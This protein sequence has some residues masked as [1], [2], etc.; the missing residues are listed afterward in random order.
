[1]E[2]LEYIFDTLLEHWP[3]VCAI[4]M[5]Y[6]IGQLFKKAAP[7]ASEGKFWA[8]L[9]RILPLHPFLLGLIMGMIPGA[10][11]P[12]SAKFGPLSGMLYFAGAGVIACHIRDIVRT[13]AKYKYNVD[14]PP[15]IPP[16]AEGEVDIDVSNV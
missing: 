5:F 14:I 11:V 2:S 6:S 16:S 7:A 8:F 4:G 1:M 12:A 10:P 13:W 15:S 9:W 3:F